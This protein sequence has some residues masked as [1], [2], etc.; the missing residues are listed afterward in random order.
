MAASMKVVL[1]KATKMSVP[2]GSVP[3]IAGS[4]ACTPRA[5]SRLLEVEVLTTPRPMLGW[6]L[7]RK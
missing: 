1:S 3:W 6:P 7:P 4:A 2:V 5:T